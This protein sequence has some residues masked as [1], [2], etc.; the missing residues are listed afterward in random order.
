MST[1]TSISSFPNTYYPASQAY[2]NSGSTSIILGSVNYGSTP[3]SSGD[4]LLVIQMQGAQINATNNA[5]YGDGTGTGRGYLNNSA[6]LAGNM[7][8]V[9]ASNSVPLTGG[10]LNVASPLIKSYKNT[11]FG[12]ETR[13][14][15]PTHD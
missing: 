1:N 6:L 10:T 5:N 11:P 15:A 12:T 8:Y 4:I 7:E 3:I 2:V 13:D 9:V 14:S